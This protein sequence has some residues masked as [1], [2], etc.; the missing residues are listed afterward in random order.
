MKHDRVCV[1]V[2]SMLFLLLFQKLLIVEQRACTADRNKSLPIAQINCA[3]AAPGE[4]L[5]SRWVLMRWILSYTRNRAG[6]RLEQ[7]TSNNSNIHLR[8]KKRQ[9]ARWDVSGR[10]EKSSRREN[11]EFWIV[12]CWFPHLMHRTPQDSSFHVGSSFKLKFFL[13]TDTHLILRVRVHIYC[14][15]NSDATFASL[16]VFFLR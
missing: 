15:A 8:E 6:Y 11:S 13:N 4:K 5:L 9:T 10:F 1:S 16:V 14:N 12:F 3:A 2:C 7:Q